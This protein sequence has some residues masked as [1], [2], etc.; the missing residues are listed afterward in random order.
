MLS[1]YET[2]MFVADFRLGAISMADK[3]KRV[4]M[5]IDQ[6]GLLVSYF[7]SHSCIKLFNSLILHRFVSSLFIYDQSL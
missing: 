7:S 2:L 4:E 3:V 5:L 6:L 1:V